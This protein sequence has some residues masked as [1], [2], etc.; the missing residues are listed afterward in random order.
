M[1]LF[2]ISDIHGSIDDLN[3]AL[4]AFDNEKADFLVILGDILYH[5]PRNPLP[6][7]YNPQEVAT[8]LNSYKEKIIAIRGNCDSEVDQMLLKFPIMSDFSQILVDK[9]RFFLTHGH[10]YNENS[11]PPLGENDILCHGHTH[12]L[13]AKQTENFVVFNP[14]SITFPKENNEKSYGIYENDCLRIYNLERALIKKLEI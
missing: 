12:V 14:G 11:L 6:K 9:K 8:K 10:T 7:N 13:V 4:D 1:K 2:F 5:G 3:Q